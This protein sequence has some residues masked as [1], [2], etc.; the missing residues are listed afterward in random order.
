MKVCHTDP[1][2]KTRFT[3]QYKLPVDNPVNNVRKRCVPG[4]YIFDV[5][6]NHPRAHIMGFM[7]LIAA[8][9]L[10]ESLDLSPPLNTDKGTIDF[11]ISNGNNAA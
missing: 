1:S 11:R 6:I 3:V 2:P 4:G 8:N 10:R 7:E 9:E 5:P